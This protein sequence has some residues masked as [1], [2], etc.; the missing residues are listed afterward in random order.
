MIDV[1]PWDQVR[2]GNESYPATPKIGKPIRFTATKKVA[3]EFERFRKISA[4]EGGLVAKSQAALVLQVSTQR[5]GDLV[6]EKRLR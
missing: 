3:S 4:T 1:W 5:V 2:E 6:A